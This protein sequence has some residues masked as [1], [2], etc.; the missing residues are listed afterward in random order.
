MSFAVTSKQIN[1]ALNGNVS[2]QANVLATGSTTSRSLSNRFSDIINVKDYGAVGNGIANDT[3][4]IQSAINS[5][6]SGNN[7][8]IVVPKGNYNLGSNVSVNGRVVSWNIDAA[9]TFSGAGR[10]PS[11][12][13]DNYGDKGIQN[14]VIAVQKGTGTAPNNNAGALAIFKKVSNANVISE[15]NTTVVFA[16]EKRE[17][18]ATD[19]RATALFAEALDFSG[20]IRAFTEG[21]RFHSIAK[22]GS[23]N[24]GAYGAVSIGG[25]ETAVDFDYLVGHEAVVVNKTVDAP[26]IPFF[27]KG[28]YTAC[29]VATTNL[30]GTKKVDVG[31]ITNPFTTPETVMRTGFM[32]AEDSVD[33]TAFGLR[34]NVVIGLDLATGSTSYAAIKFGNAQPIRVTNAA[35]TGDLNVF[36]VNS[37]DQVVL[38]TQGNGVQAGIRDTAFANHAVK[39]L[40]YGP[41]DS[42]G[43]G[44]RMVVVPN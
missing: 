17:V 6:S 3:A 43:P 7:V 1:S 39:E 33:D 18:T 9:A 20:G 41:P 27:D 32:V 12:N 4:A 15:Q 14:S 26:T 31:F 25:A 28:H 44:Y 35:A 16:I 34:A 5:A 2:L 30:G 13:T 22:V 38:G 19:S 37:S 11:I 10:L 40:L 36:V 24:S 8:E 29:F 42:G 23:V 21:G